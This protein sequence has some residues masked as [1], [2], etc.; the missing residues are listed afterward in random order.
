VAFVDPE[1]LEAAVLNVALNA[2]DAMPDGGCLT[3]R[4][5]KVEIADAP[6]T[7]D[8]LML[9]PLCLCRTKAGTPATGLRGEER[10]AHLLPKPF[11][12]LQLDQ[13]VNAVCAMSAAE[14]EATVHWP[15]RCQRAP[16]TV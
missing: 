3:I 1:V 7:A 6:P 11:S 12:T 10:G 9:E 2:R 16:L 14:R 13:A 15:D 5:Q 8:D 4:T